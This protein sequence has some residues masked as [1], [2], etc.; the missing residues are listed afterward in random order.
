MKGASHWV[1]VTFEQ[2][3][4]KKETDHCSFSFTEKKIFLLD[5]EN[6]EVEFIDDKKK[7]SILNFK[8]E[9]LQ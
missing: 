4:K 8:I 3:K 5:S 7:K 2:L 1:S 6:K 9:L